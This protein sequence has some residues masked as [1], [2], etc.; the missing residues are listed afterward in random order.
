MIWLLSFIPRAITFFRH[1]KY[2]KDEDFKASPNYQQTPPAF[3][4]CKESREALMTQ[5]TP[6]LRTCIDY[7]EQPAQELQWTLPILFSYMIDW[8]VVDFIELREGVQRHEDFMEN[9][10]QLENLQEIRNVIIEHGSGLYRF[11]Q[12]RHWEDVWKMMPSVENVVIAPFP[13]SKGLEHLENRLPYYASQRLSDHL[14]A[15]KSLRSAELFPEE[16]LVSTIQ[17]K[18]GLKKIVIM[19]HSEG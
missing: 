18:D 1:G 19:I 8:I 16:H 14:P 12:Q 7:R 4:V 13:L 17:T 6:L 10:R 9:C 11:I 2:Y 15:F 3:S 5:Y